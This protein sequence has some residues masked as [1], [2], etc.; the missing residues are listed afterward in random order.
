MRNPTPPTSIEYGSSSTR[1]NAIDNLGKIFKDARKSQP[2][3]ILTL[4]LGFTSLYPTYIFK[5]PNLT[6][7]HPDG[8]DDEN[9]KIANL[10]ALELNY[11]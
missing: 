9:S 1:S 5:N 3:L 11:A 2:I 6:D 7:K 8:R 4:E 10:W